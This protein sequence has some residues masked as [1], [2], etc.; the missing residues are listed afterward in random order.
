[1]DNGSPFGTVGP[2]GFSRLSAWWAALGIRV[3]FIAP[4]HAEQN[5]G[6]EQMHRVMKAETA[7]PTSVHRRAQQRRTDRW[8]KGYNQ[9]RPHE[10]LGQRPPAELYRSKRMA[11][12]KVK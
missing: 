9:I 2:A 5:G 11:E 4:G 8:V 10:A 7:R 6:H 3:E 12:R 1:M